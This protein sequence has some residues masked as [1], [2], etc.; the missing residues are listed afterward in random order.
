MCIKSI[1]SYNKAPCVI[2]FAIS[3]DLNNEICIKKIRQ[4]IAKFTPLARTECHTKNLSIHCANLQQAKEVIHQIKTTVSNSYLK[5]AP[6]TINNI[7]QI[8]L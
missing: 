4:I 3:D 7:P 6:I 1:A 2:H 8:S 5:I